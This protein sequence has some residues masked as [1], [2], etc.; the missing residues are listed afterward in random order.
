MRGKCCLNGCF[1]CWPDAYQGL[2]LWGEPIPVVAGRFAQGY[3]TGWRRPS[4]TGH[5]RGLCGVIRFGNPHIKYASSAV[6]RDT[7]RPVKTILE[8]HRAQ[9][10]SPSSEPARVVGRS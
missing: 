6:K 2:D 5:P 1:F 8:V 4:V 9:S 3:R 7:S 10:F